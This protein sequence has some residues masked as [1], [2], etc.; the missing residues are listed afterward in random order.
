MG[1]FR[2]GA[3]GAA[4]PLFFLYSQNV[5]RILLWKSSVYKMLFHF[6]FRNVNV[7]LYCASRIRSQCCRLHALKS[8]VC[9]RKGRGV[10]EIRPPLSEFLDPALEMTKMWCTPSVTPVSPVGGRWHWSKTLKI[11]PRKYQDSVAVAAIFVHPWKVYI[12][13]QLIISCHLFFSIP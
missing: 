9:I 10:K 7:T 12:L 4:P 5:L 13:K 3:K 11:T 1:G 8:E 6:I 2:G